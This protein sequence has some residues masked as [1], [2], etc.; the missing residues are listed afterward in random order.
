VIRSY[1]SPTK[2][3]VIDVLEVTKV[4]AGKNGQPPKT[5]ILEKHVHCQDE[6]LQT[7]YTTNSGNVA[8]PSNV[9]IK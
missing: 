3:S 2:N 7:Q 4:I 5:V 8:I 9:E 1:Y 6:E